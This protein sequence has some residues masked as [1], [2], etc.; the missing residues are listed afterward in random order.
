VDLSDA[1]NR[2]N[3]LVR[4]NDLMLA[5][6]TKPG[7]S[8]LLPTHPAETVTSSRRQRTRR[9]QKTRLDLVRAIPFRQPKLHDQQFDAGRLLAT[10]PNGDASESIPRGY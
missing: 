9:Y 4:F 3:S 6:Q 7:Q 10:A 2:S 5:R 1:A 8:L